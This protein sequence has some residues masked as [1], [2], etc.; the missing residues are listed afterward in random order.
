MSVNLPRLLPPTAETRDVIVILG[1][2]QLWARGGRENYF[3]LVRTSSAFI[4]NFS[5]ADR[6]RGGKVEKEK[7]NQGK[8][9]LETGAT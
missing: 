1:N 3:A 9:L 6:G 4:Q 8:H 5:A 7:K 2:E